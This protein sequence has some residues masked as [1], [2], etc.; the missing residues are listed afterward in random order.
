M[1]TITR[2]LARVLLALLC[3]VGATVPALAN[4]SLSGTVSTVATLGSGSG[5][6]GGLDFRVYLTGNP[7]FCSGNTWA[8]LN[9]TDANYSAIVAS[10]LSARAMGATITIYWIIGTSGYCQISSVQW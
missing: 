9:V 8:Y 10:I 3:A 2:C 4:G 7:A 1:K 5:A 6:P